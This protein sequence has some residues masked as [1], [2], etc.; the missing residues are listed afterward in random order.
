MSREIIFPKQNKK[1]YTKST[2]KIAKF[3]FSLT[4]TTTTTL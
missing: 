4:T 3:H 2:G 1:K